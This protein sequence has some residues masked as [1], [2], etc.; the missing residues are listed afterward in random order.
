MQVTTEAI[1]LRRIPY[2][3]TSLVVHL[4]SPDR[5]RIT[6]L[7]KGAFR[8]QS[9][10]FGGLDLLDR[11]EARLVGRGDAGLLL[12][13]SS[14]LQSSPRSLRRDA[15]RLAAALYSVELVDAA[16]PAAPSPILYHRF[17][18][19]LDWLE[20]IEEPSDGE[21][22]RALAA[23]ESRFLEDIGLAPV[24]E[25]CAHDRRELDPAAARIAYSV[26]AG[27]LLCESC[28]RLAD[29]PPSLSAAAAAW[30]RALRTGDPAPPPSARDLAELRA[31]LDR[32]H[33]YHLERTLR[34]RPSIEALYRVRD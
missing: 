19:W 3:D 25:R 1:V 6:A 27:G 23:F 24:L 17:R 31:L 13:G 21:L 15:R 8:P 16:L 32:F 4:F 5:G 18:A 34:A 9:P 10:H 22:A 28:A 2:A 20:E 14:A 12:L 26:R 29:R 30:M 33:T 7:A 11:I